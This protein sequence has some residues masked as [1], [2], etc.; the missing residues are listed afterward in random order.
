MLMEGAEDIYDGSVIKTAANWRKKRVNQVVTER[1][2]KDKKS[3]NSSDKNQKGAE[4][5][6]RADNKKI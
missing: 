4:D 6:K 1:D 5:L 2:D 3:E